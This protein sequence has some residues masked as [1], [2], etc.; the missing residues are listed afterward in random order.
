MR[1]VAV[2]FEEAAVGRGPGGIVAGGS[3]LPARHIIHGL[4]DSVNQGSDRGSFR[5][6]GGRR[7]SEAFFLGRQG[8]LS[9]FYSA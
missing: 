4:E 1:G 7:F 2:G 5:G 3:G 9:G 6:D 8:S